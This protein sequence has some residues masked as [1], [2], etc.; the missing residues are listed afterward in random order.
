VAGDAMTFHQSLAQAQE[1]GQAI[2]DADDREHFERSL[3]ELS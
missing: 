3:A 1:A 2:A